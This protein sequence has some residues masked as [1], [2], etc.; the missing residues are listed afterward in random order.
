MTWR[1]IFS[2]VLAIFFFASLLSLGPKPGRI[3]DCSKC[4]EEPQAP[5]E[6]ISISIIVVNLP[7]FGDNRN[8][9]SKGTHSSLKITVG[10]FTGKC[11]PLQMTYVY[12]GE[13]E[14]CHFNRP[15]D[16]NDNRTG[17]SPPLKAPEHANLMKINCRTLFYCHVSY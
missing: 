16:L 10:P 1:E 9:H 8:S 4:N 7:K 6:V 13:R 5:S 15:P 11:K 12:Y 14:L 2:H 3:I 17:C